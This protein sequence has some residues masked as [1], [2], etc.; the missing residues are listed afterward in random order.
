LPIAE[1]SCWRHPTI[2]IENAQIVVSLSGLTSVTFGTT[3]YPTELVT[4]KL[5]HDVLTAVALVLDRA[6]HSNVA[7]Q[8]ACQH[9]DKSRF[10]DT[11]E[12]FFPVL[13]AIAKGRRLTEGLRLA[14]R[15]LRSETLQWAQFLL[16]PALMRGGGSLSASEREDLRRLMKLVI[17]RFEALGQKEQAATA[18][19][20]LANHLRA[21]RGPHDRAALRHY[22]LALKGDP[23]YRQRHYFWREVG[24]VL[25]GLGR[26]GFSSRAYERAVRLGAAKDCV[27]LHADAL[28]FAGRY[29][30]AGPP[31][32]SLSPPTRISS[33]HKARRSAPP[34]YAHPAAEFALT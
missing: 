20:N 17:E 8:I 24:G 34:S 9:L 25:F 21:Q 27:A 13:R 10:L 1:E 3:T 12:V 7:A 4:T 31:Q 16:M 11:P 14:E 30:E 2:L 29:G 15:L 32:G 28:M 6:G 23:V 26:F 5:P 22:R 33:T 19:Y 18:H